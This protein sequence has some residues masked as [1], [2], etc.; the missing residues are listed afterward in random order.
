MEFI[1][2]SLLLIKIFL[3]VNI[4]S[5]LISRFFNV[6]M[7]P[8]GVAACG[9]FGAIAKKNK[10]IDIVKIAILGLYNVQRGTDSCGYYYNGALKKGVNADSNWSDF[11]DS[12]KIKPGKLN[13][14]I[15]MGHTR[16]STFGASNEENAHPH[17]INN[18]Y[19][20]THNGTLKNHWELC[21][22]R[23]I[24]HTKIHVDSIALGT[25]IENENGFEVLSEY[26]GAAALAMT[27]IDDPKA[28]YLFHGASREKEGESLIEE[29]PLFILDLPE[30]LYYSSMENS[31]NFIAPNSRYKPEI[32]EHNKVFKFVDGKCEGFVYEA[33]RANV[34]LPKIYYYGGG[35]TNNNEDKSYDACRSTFERTNNTTNTT[36]ASAVT[37]T[38]EGRVVDMNNFPSLWLS[39]SLPRESAT[40]QIYFVKGRYCRTGNILLDGIYN[41]NREGNII[42]DNGDTNGDGT[43]MSV[44]ETFY[45]IRGIMMRNEEDYKT[46]LTHKNIV[47]TTGA[48]FAYR[49]S[50]LSKY[51]VMALEKEGLA[52]PI[53]YLMG[54]AVTGKFSMKFTKRQY[55]FQNGELKSI[56]RAEK[57]DFTHKSGEKIELAVDNSEGYEDIYAGIEFYSDCILTLD[58]LKTLPEFFLMAIDLYSMDGKENP[59][60][61]EEK[62]NNIIDSLIRDGISYKQ[63]LFDRN[64]IAY[65]DKD[66]LNEELL[67]W[68][69]DALKSM[70]NRFQFI[71]LDDNAEIISK[72]LITK[73]EED[74]DE[75]YNPDK[76]YATG[77]DLP[78]K[79]TPNLDREL[80]GGEMIDKVIESEFTAEAIDYINDWIKNVE[81]NLEIVES[82]NDLQPL[83]NLD[84]V[85]ISSLERILKMEKNKLVDLKNKI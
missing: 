23:K 46:G 64:D 81:Y 35:A 38:Q 67:H 52:I 24:N 55:V 77:D 28:L 39:E 50:L 31:L 57:D 58:N 78:F 45:F 19:V 15:F 25:I 1:L 69:P 21:N 41:I 4:I 42:T 3:V 14:N 5:L 10:Q 54:T 73:P 70:E 40:Q 36:G 8:R 18:R 30:A 82:L 74:V 11:I 48:N 79:E 33:K 20:Q 66:I 9:I 56:I 76:D 6:Q 27:F 26:T 80:T 16:K 51:P 61:L 85:V 47:N 32:L 63:Y 22:V 62:T 29:R 53:A 44:I 43:S 72:S 68:G 17:L 34:N 12:N 13:T 49:M 83:K 84:P 75:N 71:D 60:E 7:L 65:L 2:V 37:A 59:G